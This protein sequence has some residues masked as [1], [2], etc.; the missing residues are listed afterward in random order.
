MLCAYCLLAINDISISTFLRFPDTQLSLK[1]VHSFHIRRVRRLAFSANFKMSLH[2]LTRIYMYIR[3]EAKICIFTN[4]FCLSLSKTT[5]LRLRRVKR[6]CRS[7]K[8][9]HDLFRNICSSG[10]LSINS[11]VISIIKLA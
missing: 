8:K 5:A 9:S 3:A 6:D 1:C 7:G 2:V 11:P 4:S 10:G